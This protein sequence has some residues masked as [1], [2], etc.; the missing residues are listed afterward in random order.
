MPPKKIVA[1][2]SA[3]AKR[4]SARV[5]VRAISSAKKDKAPEEEEAEVE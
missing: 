3:D 5:A 2:C 1:A 4:K